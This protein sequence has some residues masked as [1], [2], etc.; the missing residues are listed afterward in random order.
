[1]L[2]N[3]SLPQVIANGTK[4]MSIRFRNVKYI[5]SHCFIPM[6][7]SAFAKTFELGVLK[8]GMFFV[9]KLNRFKKCFY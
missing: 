9:Y 5:D 8:K 4:L 3:E 1:M 2:P 7:L 6:P